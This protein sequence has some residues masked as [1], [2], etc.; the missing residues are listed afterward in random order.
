MKP[1]IFILTLL[2]SFN[3]YAQEKVLLRQMVGDNETFV[4]AILEGFEVFVDGKRVDN[5]NYVVKE[6]V[7]HKEYI[8]GPGG[9]VIKTFTLFQNGYVHISDDLTNRVNLKSEVL[10]FKDFKSKYPV[11]T[12]PFDLWF[13]EY[14]H[15]KYS[16]FLPNGV[17]VKIL[18]IHAD[19]AIEVEMLDGPKKGSRM[20]VELDMLNTNEAVKWVKRYKGRYAYFLRPGTRYSPLLKTEAKISHL[21][22]D[23]NG[24]NWYMVAHTDEGK[25]ITWAQSH[26]QTS[27]HFGL[28]VPSKQKVVRLADSPNES[29][30][31]VREFDNEVVITKNPKNGG[32]RFVGPKEILFKNGSCNLDFAALF[33]RSI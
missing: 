24:R 16:T 11:G 33:K 27:P 20:F 19:G 6:I 5:I 14:K 7:V 29:L 2:I 21:E 32:I 18:S 17:E 22:Q 13:V 15:G 3:S 9:T 1:I 4:P 23:P 12:I 25:A 10:T 8:R 30:E 28:E 26:P 31:V